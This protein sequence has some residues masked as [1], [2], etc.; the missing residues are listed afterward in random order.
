MVKVNV[1]IKEEGECWVKMFDEV[2]N[3][4]KIYINLLDMFGILYLGK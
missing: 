2:K 3:N 4:I 1:L